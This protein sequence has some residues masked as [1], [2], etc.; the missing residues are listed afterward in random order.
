MALSNADK[1]KLL[2]NGKEISEQQVDPYEMNTWFVPYK[3]GKLEAI[4]YKNGKIVSRTKVETTK[5]PV[6]V[7]LTPDRNNL[8][9]DGRDA[10]PI[11][12]EVID[13]KG[14][15]VPTANHMIEFTVTGPAEIIGLG[16]GDPNCHEPE[17]GNKRSLFNG[18][19]SDH[20][21]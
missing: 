11:T 14:R 17:K 12:V 10:M 9:G 6:Q 1:V 7:R 4:G 3:P 21:K 18:L 5:E 19:A 8:A 13:S 16:N 20:P 2:L 15:H